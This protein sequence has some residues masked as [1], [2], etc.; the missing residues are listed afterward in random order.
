MAW[1]RGSIPTQTK[2]PKAANGG[3]AEHPRFIVSRAC[4]GSL[5]GGDR[6]NSQEEREGGMLVTTNHR[7]CVG[8]M[9]P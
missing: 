6:P 3:R 5:L 9:N 2:A 1:R 4:E 8:G 7:G